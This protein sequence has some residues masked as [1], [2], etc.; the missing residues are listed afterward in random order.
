M[1]IK[2]LKIESKDKII[3]DIQ[4]KNGLNLI[5]DNTPINL[6][7]ETGNN[8]GKTTVLKLIDFCLGGKADKITKDKESKNTL[9]NIKDF[10]INEEVVITLIISNS[11]TTDKNDIVIR[12]N[13]LNRNK[14]ILEINGEKLTQNGEKLFINKLS[15]LLFGERLGDKPSL[16]SLLAHSIRYSDERISNTLRMLN[17]HTTLS[18]YETLFLFMFGFK[19]LDR[20][21]LIKKLKSEENFINKLIGDKDKIQLELQLNMIESNIEKLLLEKD[22][23]VIN[24]NY[25]YNI[26]QINLYKLEINKI[27]SKISELELRKELLYETKNELE[28]S[29]SDVSIELIKNMYDQATKFNLTNI[30]KKL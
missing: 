7:T 9:Y 8:V 29:Y 17:N 1:Y 23:L 18:E 16:R 11:F 19:S 12:R 22:N 6:K 27:Y 14:K 2:R 15:F 26:Q 30:Q 20:T 4:F 3:R 28:Q 5:V 25:E 10:L 24:K 21:E 13:F